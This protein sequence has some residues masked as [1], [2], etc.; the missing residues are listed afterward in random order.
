MKITDVLVAEHRIFEGVFAQIE[1]ALPRLRT[2][3]E[4]RLLAS[5]V[6][7]LLT[8]HSGTETELAFLALD[9]VRQD[10]GRLDRLHQDHQEI[11]SRLRQVQSARTGGD[12]RRLLAAA[13]QASRQH[14]LLEERAIFPLLERALQP[15][16]LAELAATWS[17]RAAASRDRPH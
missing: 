16:T 6:E 12:A 15:A 1:A 4:V 9:H 11:D 14:M 3:A 17:L 7:G 8:A 13:L 5:I 10:E 2:L